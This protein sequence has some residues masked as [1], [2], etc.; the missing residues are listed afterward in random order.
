MKIPARVVTL[1]VG[2]PLVADVTVE[3]G[4]V[5]VI[6]A[7]GHG[8]TNIVALGNVDYVNGVAVKVLTSD[9]LYHLGS[10]MTRQPNCGLLQ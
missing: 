1:V 10:A 7:K 3:A 2:N 6:T 8:T 4:G 9:G 5:A